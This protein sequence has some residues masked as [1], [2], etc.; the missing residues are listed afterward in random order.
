MNGQRKSD[1][2]LNFEARGS[3]CPSYMLMEVNKGNAAMVKEFTA[4]NPHYPVS[5][6]LMYSIY[7][8]LPND[9]DLTVFREQGKIQG[10]NFAFIDNHF[11]Y[12]TQ[13]DDLQ[14]LAP[15]TSAHQGSYLMPLLQY[16]SNSD[17]SRLDSDEDFVYF[18]TPFNFISYPFSWNLPLLVVAFV[19]FLGL[20]FVGIGKRVLHFKDILKGFIPL[21]G[22]LFSAGLVTFFG[23]KLMLILYPQY[24]DI[25][26]GFTYNGHS[27]IAAFIALSLAF[28]FWFYK[29]FAE[30]SKMMDY[31]VAPLLLWFIINTGIVFA[32]PGAGFFIIPL[33][34]GLISLGY[35][36]IT[37]KTNRI[38]YTILAFP[39]VV[40][41]VPFIVM[42]P[43]GL[44]LK[45]LFG[46]AILVILTF[47]LLLPVLGLFSKKGNWSFLMALIALG[48]FINAHLNSNYESG[49]AKQ[50]SLV[51]MFD[52]DKNKA[53][54]TTY[55]VNLDDWT[56]GYLG[57]NPK[58]AEALNGEKLFSK[59]N[60]VFTFMADAPVKTLQK[61]TITFVKDTVVGDWRYLKIAISP[62]RKV[63]RYDIFADLKMNLQH[64]KAND[65][66]ALGAKNSIYKRKDRKILSYYVVDNEPLE[67]Q[68]TIEKNT[69]LDMSLLESSFDL[70]ENS[71]FSVAHRA[72]WMMPT[73]F[74]LNDAVVIKEKI[75]PGQNQ[76]T[77]ILYRSLSERPNRC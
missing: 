64:F 66:S 28:A 37:Q 33:Y 10:Y 6:S 51:Y 65:V 50:N 40:I 4:A 7:K 60:S 49:K 9:T 57:E 45:I 54:L 38:L 44:G 22:S 47:T 30:R 72:D 18:N 61:P 48:C 17:L 76:F 53:F 68:F 70:L 35:F 75:K 24:N 13:Q 39:A 74:V 42:F 11:N 77:G 46:S 19:L 29:K 34:F 58:T 63:N 2:S 59:Y 5:N 1:W 23:W 55:D 14:H 41:L 69:K 8:M 12:H 62:N 31:F 36:I 27:Y 25:L 32:L 20:I 67:M 71:E 26:H 56:K 21:L 43:I 3:A 15:N 16:F 52:A 73:P